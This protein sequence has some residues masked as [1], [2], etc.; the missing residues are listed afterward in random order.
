MIIEMIAYFFKN[1]VSLPRIF[2]LT[3]TDFQ[4]LFNK[5]GINF[6]A[7]PEKRAQHYIT[8][9]EQPYLARGR[10]STK[11]ALCPQQRQAVSPKAG[12]SGSCYQDSDAG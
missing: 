9:A 6:K 5:A 7:V 1:T 2:S 11:A 8:S 3:R 4:A 12:L 10:S